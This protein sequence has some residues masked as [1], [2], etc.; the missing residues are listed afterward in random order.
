M[1]ADI[2]ISECRVDHLVGGGQIHLQQNG[3]GRK[4]VTDVVKPIADVVGRKLIGR[5]QVEA[6]E[7]TNRVVVFLA[8]E[9]TN[10]DSLVSA[11]VFLSVQCQARN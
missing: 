3:R 8:I 5:M 1:L 7:V 6:D 10:G 4:H 9:A 11:V 2:L